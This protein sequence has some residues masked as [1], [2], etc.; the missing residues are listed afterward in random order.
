M[1]S[2]S[3]ATSRSSTIRDD[4]LAW[5]ALGKIPPG[6][7]LPP[8]PQLAG[9]LRVSRPT[10]REA[11]RSLE[12]EGVVTRTRGSGTFLSHRP[13]VRNNLDVNFGVSDAIRQAGMKPGAITAVTSIERPPSDERERLALGPDEQVVVV[14]RVRTADGRPIVFTRDVL[15]VRLLDGRPDIIQRLASGSIY[16]TMERDLGVAIHHGVASFTPVR[17]SKLLASKLRVAR[18]ALLLYLR[19]VDYDQAGRPVL[20]SHEHHLA[21]AFE[22][23]L[24]RRGPGRRVT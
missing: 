16:E 24:V 22:F 14:E 12:D 11:L 7:Q 4:L 19:Q 17:A 8:E 9:E 1:R 10:L 20:S 18:G 15:P 6:G 13:R 3:R 21:D 23:T 5:I 2:T